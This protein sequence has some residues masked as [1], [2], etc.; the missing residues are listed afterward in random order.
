[1]CSVYRGRGLWGTWNP[2]A[3]TAVLGGLWGRREVLGGFHTEADL[4]SR[5]WVDTGSIW[6]ARRS[7]VE[8][9]SKL[10]FG[11]WSKGK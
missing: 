2:P 1:M 10:G 6:I 7:I 8:G 3:A 11:A 9:E 4:P 5:L